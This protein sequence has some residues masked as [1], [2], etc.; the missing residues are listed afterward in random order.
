MRTADRLPPASEEAERGVLGAVLLDPDRVMDLCLDRHVHPDWFYIPAHRLI[1]E[2]MLKLAAAQRPVDSLHVPEAMRDAG[3]FDQ[4]GGMTAIER[5]MDSTPTPAHA[6]YYLD[7]IA[8]KY[9]LRRLIACAREIEAG[10][11][12]GEGTAES[13]RSEAEFMFAS[14][15][16]RSSRERITPEEALKTFIE[17]VQIARTSGCAGIPT[18][19]RCIDTYLG[20]L[21]ECA[22]IVLSGGPGSGKTSLARNICENLAMRSEPI[23]SLFFSLEQPA[24]MI[25]GAMMTRHMR[26]SMYRLIV[27]HANPED[28]ARMVA[29]AAAVARWP[30][31]VDD[32]P[33]TPATLWSRTRQAIRKHG[34]KLVVIDYL[35]KIKA[36]ADYKSDEQRITAHSATVTAIAKDLR[37]PVICLSSLSN[38]GTLRGS[39]AISFDAW[40]IISMAATD[41]KDP[42]GNCIHTL[43][44]EKQRFGPKFNDEDLILLGNESR[45]A[46]D[47]GVSDMPPEFSGAKPDNATDSHAPYSPAVEQE[48]LF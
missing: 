20:G 38:T 48:D 33:Q 23:P 2:S 14:I 36:D 31:I 26:E 15:L 5:I 13:L 11:Y 29:S 8:D 7:I 25:Y 41:R 34:V 22:M 35:Q 32:R 39:G 10:A 18:G 43:S 46:E 19:F 28:D 47:T 9:M 45:F 40:G 21:M 37:I 17:R 16:E 27:G 44:L 12:E 6:E 30:I 3:T 1:F 4:V 24:E 42:D